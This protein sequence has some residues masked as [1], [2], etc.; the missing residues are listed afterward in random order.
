MDKRG[1]SS[2]DLRA[3]TKDGRELLRQADAGPGFP[4]RP[5]AREDHLSRFDD[6]L[7]FAEKRIAA[8]TA[9]RIIDSIF[10]LEKMRDVREL[11]PLFA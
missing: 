10:N 6:C 1:H 11:L 3:W 8:D 2:A 4:Q 9:T 7:A 5:L